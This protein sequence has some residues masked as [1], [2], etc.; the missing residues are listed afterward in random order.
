METIGMVAGV[1]AIVILVIYV[2]DRKTKQQP[3]DIMDAVKFMFGASGIAGGVA[4]A[5]SGTEEAIETTT[6]VVQDMFVGKPE[7]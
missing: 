7:F 3:I 1:V 6:E 4:Y 2:W 5:V